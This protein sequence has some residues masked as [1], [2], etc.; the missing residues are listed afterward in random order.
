MAWP[1]QAYSAPTN[2][3]SAKSIRVTTLP[4]KSL[5]VMEF[6][7]TI[8]RACKVLENSQGYGKS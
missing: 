1:V 7:K 8:F 6:S 4:G 5:K 2:K 3:I